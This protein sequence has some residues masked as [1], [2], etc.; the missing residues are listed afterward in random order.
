MREKGDGRPHVLVGGQRDQR[1][2]LRRPF[3]EYGARARR[4]E[5]GPYGPGR[6]GPVVAH[7]EQQGPGPPVAVAHA[8]TS[9][10][11]R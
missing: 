10:Q 7:P 2:G 6:A 11:A 5:R 8:L 1:V 4:F 3:D 9:R